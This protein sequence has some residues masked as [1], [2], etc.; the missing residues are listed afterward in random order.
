M[1]IVQFGAHTVSLKVE[2]GNLITTFMLCTP[3]LVKICYF[4][5]RNVLSVDRCNERGY[6]RMVADETIYRW[7]ML[8]FQSIPH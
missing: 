5:L 4:N 8:F 7:D 6:V 2:A 3:K 1:K